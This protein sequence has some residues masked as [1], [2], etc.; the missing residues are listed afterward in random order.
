[1]TDNKARVDEVQVHGKAHRAGEKVRE[2]G[3]DLK[4]HARDVKESA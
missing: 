1:M 2:M 4:E 3:D